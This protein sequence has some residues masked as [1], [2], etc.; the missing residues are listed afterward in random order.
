MYRC[1]N[2]FKGFLSNVHFDTYNMLCIYQ[3]LARFDNNHCLNDTCLT[4][5]DVQ[6]AKVHYISTGETDIHPPERKG[7]QRGTSPKESRT[8]EGDGILM[9]NKAHCNIGIVVI[10]CQ[11]ITAFLGGSEKLPG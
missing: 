1:D 8:I 7:I 11:I 5:S 9:V 4:I 6:R 10:H 2:F 3:L